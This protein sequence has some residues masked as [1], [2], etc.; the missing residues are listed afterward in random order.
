[1]IRHGE[2]ESNTKGIVSS[3]RGKNGDKLTL[4][5]KGQVEESIIVIDKILKKETKNRNGEKIDIIISSP[6]TR[7]TETA[8]ILKD[9]LDFQGD[10][11]FDERIRER[12]FVDYD[13]KK[14]DSYYSDRSEEGVHGR[15]DFDAKT[16]NGESKRETRNR[17]MEFFYE[18]DKKYEGKNILVVTHFDPLFLAFSGLKGLN[19]EEVKTYRD[20]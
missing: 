3:T 19:G 7:T 9:K 15:D 17:M 13:G 2:S 12:S 6:F 14:Y 5:G 18:I 16:E 10:I 11:I 20:E 8:N 1:L 4:K